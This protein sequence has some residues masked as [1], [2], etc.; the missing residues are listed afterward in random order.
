MREDL[1]SKPIYVSHEEARSLMPFFEAASRSAPYEE[2]KSS[3]MRILRELRSV[4]GDV[5][6]E[7][8]GGKQIFL[9]PVDRAWLEEVMN[10]FGL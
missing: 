7:P 5:K 2:A 6:Y 8:F 1:S 9:N 10:S 3:A 4:R